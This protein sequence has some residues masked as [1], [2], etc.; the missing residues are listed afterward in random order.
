MKKVNN[1]NKLTKKD[2]INIMILSLFVLVMFIFLTHNKYIYGSTTDWKDQHWLFPEYF[3]NLFYNTG[4]II[5][6]FAFNI[7]GGQN[8]FNFA[9]YGFLNPI[10]L[11]SYFF[12]F[13]NMMDYII[14]SSL[15]IL[16][17]SVILFYKWLKNNNL[18]TDICFITTFIFI[19]AS[20]LILHSH[21]HIMFMNY[22]PFLILGLIG[23]D[24]YFKDK[25]FYLI[26]LATTLMIF[27]SYY[28]SVC[29]IVVLGI[30]YIYKYL[31]NNEKII[32]KD[33]CFSILKFCY[34]ILIAILI[35]CVLLLPV[36]ATILSGRLENVQNI[37][38]LEFFI[39]N[40]DIGYL[41][42]NSYGIGLTSISLIS[43]IIS[44]F[45]KDKS[46]KFI[47]IILGCIICFPILIYLLNGTLYVNSKVLIPFLPIIC[48]LISDA[49]KNIFDNHIDLKKVFTPLLIIII[50]SY[51]TNNNIFLVLLVDSLIM[52]LSIILYKYKNIKCIVYI[53]L[54]IITLINCLIV[55]I[56]DELY[57]KDDY[58]KDHQIEVNK[59]IKKLLES[60][61]EVF[62]VNNNLTPLSTSNKIY[63]I[64]YYQSSLYSS[65]YN[66]NYNNFYTSV[67]NNEIPYR[68]AIINGETNNLLYQIF[69]GEKYIITKNKPNLGYELIDDTKNYQIYHNTNVLPIGYSTNK[70]LDK[71]IYAEL[72]Y[73]YN[74]EALLNYIVVDNSNSKEKF[75]SN[76]EIYDTTDLE[77][78]FSNLSINNE[79]DS[80]HF[81]MDET[82]KINIP[83]ENKLNNKVLIITFDMD[84]SQ[85]CSKG[86]T[87]ITINGIKNKLTC[88]SWRYH[89]N[90][91][92]F[93]YVLATENI[94]NLNIKFS[95]GEFIINNVN[96][97]T[98]DLKYVEKINDNIDI[99]NIDRNKTK[100]NQIVGTIDVKNDGYFIL[101]V[102]YDKGFR[103]YI[104]NEQAELLNLNEGFIGS[105]IT[106]GSHNIKIIYHAPLLLIGKIISII[107]ILLY[108]ISIY[109]NKHFDT[110]K[111][112][113]LNN[114]L[115]KFALKKYKRYEEII[116]YLFI[117]G[118]TTIV[119]IGTYTICSSLFHIHYQ[120]SNIISWVFSVVFAFITNKLFVFKVKNNDNLFKE[121]YQFVKFRIL[122]LIIDMG[123]MYLLVDLLKINDIISK[124]LVQ[125]IVVALNYIFSKL[126]IFKKEK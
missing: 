45:T 103:I 64:N 29:G 76:I 8:I 20:P 113:F 35:S 55:N 114:K 28:F 11:I 125:I 71:E 63:D 116:N 48:L 56:D 95:K 126:F 86:D 70:V 14:A 98:L 40:L 22:M 72:K 121:I 5:P 17:I 19:S 92:S 9:Y 117:G 118:C 4:K 88:K 31:Q 105:K 94:D 62:R 101:K 1:M 89:N 41:L 97:Y 110:C 58:K 112:K 24:K 100:G 60:D 81:I 18:N 39:P 53:P 87:Y 57:L 12:P 10:I 47:I 122:S 51:F 99:F 3:R 69:M 104:D 93:E 34:F 7:G 49:L 16:I 66:G 79:S 43:L 83:L 90:N 46:K 91:Y 85:S 42:Y 82:T 73:P 52:V 59:S 2:Y 119:S 67:F 61:R 54:V 109:I 124:I 15:I 30:Y 26:T 50:I 25:K 27:T 106:E 102:P 23:I 74:V 44:F 96:A 78:F 32:F 36:L 38:I 123:I 111:E 84:L 80:Y 77:K 115:V 6:E 75:I 37:N 108:S 120:V 107:G 21:R 13:I 33:F 68:N 65:T